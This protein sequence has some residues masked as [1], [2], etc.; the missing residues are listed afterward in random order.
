MR[1]IVLVVLVALAPPEKPA[2]LV[3]R[4]ATV[5]FAPGRTIQPGTV[6]L[7]AGVIESVGNPL[8]V[9]R[10]AEVIDGTGLTVYAGFIDARSTIGLPETKRTAEQLRLSEGTKPD[11]TREAP[12]HM[13][14][15]NRKGLR[16]ELDAAEL[17]APGEEALKKAHAGGFTLA[18]VAAADEY[19]S[20]RSALLT[21][22]GQPRRAALLRGATVLE[23]G[24]HT[25]L[26]GYPSTTMGVVAH[27]RQV[28]LDGAQYA[29][30][31]A[32]WAP[33]RPRPPIDPALEA[34]GPALTGQMAVSF[35]A[36]TDLEI[37]RA[38][39]LADEFK[40]KIEV[41]GGREAW[42]LADVLR[43][44][45]VPVI[46]GLRHPQEPEK[47]KDAEPEPARLMEDRERVKREERSSAQALR[48]KGI[49]LAFSTAGLESPGEALS[50]IAVLVENGL[51]AEAALAA[52]T[53]S[54][55]RLLG[56]DATHGTIEKG[57]AANLTVLTAPLGDPKARV[58][59][60]VADGIKFELE[61]PSGEE[62]KKE[63]KKEERKEER[64]E[65]KKE[66][67]QAPPE[68]EVELDQD[69]IP[70]TRTGGTVFIRNARILTVADAGTIE[71][72]S[73]LVR[74]GKIAAVGS[75]LEA[76]AGVFVLDASGLTVMP[77]TID[78]HSHIATHGGLNEATESITPEVRVR[79][80]LNGH[81]VELYRASA[82][83]V[84][85]AN[86]LHGS[87]NTI[88]GQNATI[89]VRYGRSP[90]DLLFPGAP[91]GVKFALGENPTQSNSPSNAGKR[92]PN[93][94]MGVEA[95]LRRAFQEARDYGE[96]LKKDPPP[97][98]DL[99]LEALLGI[100]QGEILVH[101]HCYRADEILMVLQTARQQGF[102]VATLQHALEGYRVAPEIL[103][104]GTGVST[105]SDWWS[106]KVEAYEAIPYNAALLTQAGVLT[107]INSDL[108]PQIRH[109]TVEAAKTM[110]YGGLSEREALAQITIN[111][112]RQLGIDRLAGSIEPGKLADLALFN[113][114]PLSPYSRCVLTL[115][116][117]EVVYEKRDA[118]NHAT[119]AFA[120][121][122]RP[123][124]GLGPLPRPGR[125]VIEQ[126]TLHP[127]SS[128]PAVG[129]L[130]IDEGK[131]AFVGAECPQRFR[132]DAVTLDGKG[133][134][135][136]PGM[137]DAHTTV[138]LSEIGSI[139]G[140]QDHEE[141]GKLQP[142]L[143][144][145][146]AVN[147]HS[148][149]IPVTRANGVT[150]VLTLPTGGLIAGQSSV[151]RM[152]GWTPGEMALRKDC[153]LHVRFPD[154]PREVPPA[155]GEKKEKKTDAEADLK[156]LRE[157]FQ[158]AKRYDPKEHDPR[159]EALQPYLR[160]ERPVIFE[161]D[162]VGQIKG[163]LRFAQDLGL[164][165]VISGGEEAW[166]VAKELGE[167][168]VPVILAG[169]MGA[170]RQP[171][172]PEDAL[173]RNAARLVQAG[174][175]V[176][177]SSAEDF[178]GGSRNTPYHA[179]WAAG[180]GL[181]RDQALR[182]VTLAPAEILGIADRV[183]S[184]EVGKDADLILTT[185]DPLEVVTD[186]V[187]EFIGGRPVSLESKHTRLYE[188][189]RERI[190]KK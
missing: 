75:S 157:F 107:S 9:P 44:R 135:L 109:L 67:G 116:E 97:R 82:A 170:P 72:G 134:H 179:A 185:G 43:A 26:P 141:I 34:L 17:V 21:L 149:M 63:E 41:S 42:K 112:A 103:A 106:Y 46:L 25:Y 22:S 148:E 61:K 115:V 38:L 88:G 83:G 18:R 86:I 173:A 131:I 121:G 14:E 84:T 24:F 181:D 54:P 186:V 29:R 32:S 167:R 125:I 162:T 137:I 49:R 155:K 71:G 74:E 122:T 145:L 77:G 171:Y 118:P 154:P 39:A 60:V 166:K 114:H 108:T 3:I 147:P 127:V 160:G 176:A 113:G 2:P 55:A 40:L 169:V 35:A 76:P 62:K 133:L 98:R 156:S 50:A 189:F 47:P 28:F 151:I 174:V 183:G 99:R 129:V 79:D 8:D 6:V 184:I 87:A 90:A 182:A 78:C 119:T 140:T 31:V 19:L 23:A 136:Y 188:K 12:A 180:H 126:A 69:R 51:P 58:R 11:V 152:A 1:W 20:G 111:P 27:L 70:R 146:D 33:G 59:Y 142:D 168:Q 177:I 15:A 128:P 163:A 48:E 65:E 7:R 45:D 104:S 94:R 57:K 13:E 132:T 36:D 120:A 144:T 30:D 139:A 5:V 123:R 66:P 143:S 64:K 4:N 190:E 161:A 85:A 175:K 102:R 150:S 158:S 89:H 172:D 52:L 93:T 81:D 16:P 124:R 80:A 110:K 10:D 96:A 117:G 56:L 105:F 138:G 100:L 37:L 73:I 92:F 95:A 53:T 165:P 178:Q 153:G 130:V 164:R 187:Y 101:C 68:Y 159:L 91:R